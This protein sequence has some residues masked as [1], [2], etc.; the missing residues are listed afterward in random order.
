MYSINYLNDNRKTKRH[1]KLSNF[2][3]FKTKGFYQ[4]EPKF[5]SSPIN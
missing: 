3:F 1:E 2:L 4:F 5:N